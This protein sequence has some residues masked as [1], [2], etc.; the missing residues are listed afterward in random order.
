MDFN[1]NVAK[2]FSTFIQFYLP[3]LGVRKTFFIPLF[4]S[5][6]M[7]QN[8]IKNFVASFSCMLL[9]RTSCMNYM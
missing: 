3:F 5:N 2:L 9:A 7:N 6:K 8:Q 1:K 4:F